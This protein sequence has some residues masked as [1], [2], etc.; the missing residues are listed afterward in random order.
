VRPTTYVANE[1]LQ[2]LSSIDMDVSDPDGWSISYTYQTNFSVGFMPGFAATTTGSINT[3]GH[4]TMGPNK[5][6]AVKAPA[7]GSG[8]L[9]GIFTAVF[10]SMQ[11]TNNAVKFSFSSSLDSVIT[12]DIPEPS[13]VVMV[14][15]G[16]LCL[17]VVRAR[18]RRVT[19]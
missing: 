8:N 11:I 1:T 10:T 4:V 6:L 3:S 12:S 2:L 16:A 7:A 17:C 14:P 5:G 19:P 15:F 9:V 13:T 18:L